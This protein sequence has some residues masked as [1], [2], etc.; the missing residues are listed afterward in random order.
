M[1]PPLW[2]KGKENELNV[3]LIFT[4]IFRKHG[5][6][7]TE[8][9]IINT[10]AEF[11]YLNQTLAVNFL[12]ILKQNVRMAH[13]QWKQERMAGTLDV[14]HKLGLC[15]GGTSGSQACRPAPYFGLLLFKVLSKKLAREQKVTFSNV[16]DALVEAFSNNIFRKLYNF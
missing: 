16:E 3:C 15:P 2:E 10:S 12:F 1:G 13:Q 9:N 5:R 6:G 4:E 11:E 7:M 8:S 14:L